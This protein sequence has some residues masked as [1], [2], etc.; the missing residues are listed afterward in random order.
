MDGGC[1]GPQP[2]AWNDLT[3]KARLLATGK[4]GSATFPRVERVGMPAIGR[5]SGAA[6][7]C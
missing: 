3:T 4:T 1:P 5:R 2:A 7:E 6:R